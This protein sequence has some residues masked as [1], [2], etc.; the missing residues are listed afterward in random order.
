[1]SKPTLSKDQILD[2]IRRTA[3]EMGRRPSR[4]AFVAHT[5]ITEYQVV[6][7][8]PSWNSA[9]EAAGL[10]PYTTNVQLDDSVLLQDW[11]KVVRQL[12]HIPTRVQYRQHGEFSPEAFRRHFGPSSRI[13]ERFKEFAADKPEWNDVLMLLPP[14]A[15]DARPIG[16]SLRSPEIP[17]ALPDRIASAPLSQKRSKLNGRPIYGDPIDFRGLMHEP[18]NESGVIFLFGIV[19][20]ELGYLVEAVQGGFPDC[21]AKRQIAAGKWQRVRIEF[22]YESRNFRDHGHPVDGCDVIVCWR[23]NWPDHPPRI[24]IVELSDVIQR[25]GKSDE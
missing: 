18:V 4:P 21:E 17:V 24:H 10:E 9:V 22:E 6:R 11:G 15:A 14:S 23:D 19:A 13:P 3:A 20:R 16:L 2:A 25:L 8:F 1:M 5:G 12:C 7:H